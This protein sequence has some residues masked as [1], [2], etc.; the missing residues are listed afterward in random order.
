MKTDT[1]KFKLEPYEWQKEAIRMSYRSPELALLAE[2]GTGKTGAS[3]NILRARMSENKRFMK[4][5]ILAP[6][7]TLFNWADEIIKHSYIKRENIIILS[8]QGSGGKLKQL[9][10][11]MLSPNK[12][13]V[14]N[15]EALLSDKLFDAL[16]KWQPEI[17]ICDE[18]HMVKNPKAKRSKK[19]AKLA[20]KCSN[21]YIL[22]GTPILNQVTDIFMQYRVLDGGKTFGDSFYVFQNMY[23]IDMNAGWR[24]DKRYPD[25]QPRTEKYQELQDKIYKKAIR[26][27]KKDC[28][29]LP[30]LI[31]KTLKIEMS[32]SQLKYYKEMKRDF[33][34]YVKEKAKEGMVVAQLAVTKALRLQQIVTGFVMDEEGK[35]I[36]IADNPRINAVKELLLALQSKNK[37]IVW[38]SF[39]HNYKQ[40]GDLCKELEIDHAFLT[41]EMNLEAK[42]V[43]MD[44]FNNDIKCRVIIANRRAGGIGVNL[45]AAS[46]SIVYSRNFN[47]AD[48]LQS[49][50]RNHRGGSQIHDRIVKID[51][52][53][54]NTIDETVLEALQNKQDISDKIVELA[55]EKQNV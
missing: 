28:L 29:D 16:I 5:L 2:M 6:Q 17:L 38:C 36:E 35:V 53:A 48:E 33:I 51:L 22:T 11:E 21:R 10:K 24:G 47:L 43:A 26:V 50:A 14:V 55:K 30:P 27:L 31:K 37:I 23:M 44:R 39:R 7:V 46:Y 25:W 49:E 12:I 8:K 4:T 32:K 54:P 15:Y 3:V 41:G 20:D 34:T 40:L 13:V 19:V 45:V 52:C 18:A 9:E 1:L 42:R